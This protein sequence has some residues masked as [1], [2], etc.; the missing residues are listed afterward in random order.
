MKNHLP[1]LF[2]VAVVATV[3]F[4]QLPAWGIGFVV[5]TTDI[6]TW[7]KAHPEVDPNTLTHKNDKTRV[8]KVT[9]VKEWL[10]AHP[11]VDPAKYKSWKADEVI[12]YPSPLQPTISWPQVPADVK[13][14]GILIVS[15]D[16]KDGVVFEKEI[17]E[18]TIT[19]PKG[20]LK[21]GKTYLYQLGHIRA[22]G[23]IM[24]GGSVEFHT[25]K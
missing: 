8:V 2:R 24:D 10:K 7:L 4:I 23:E 20:V 6:K 25:E 3:G 18:R 22:N 17:V 13:K 21:P 12:S 11:N 9:T 5:N 16:P 1:H 19:L 15:K 14:T